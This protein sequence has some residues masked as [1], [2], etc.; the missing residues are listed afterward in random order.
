MARYAYDRLTAQDLSFLLAE[1]D[2]CPMH[3]GA[4][5]V[6][7]SGGLRTESGGI[8]IATCRRT[9]ESVLHWIP[10]YRQ[11]LAWIPVDTWPVWI[12]DR[13]FHLDHHV[14][15]ISL[16]RP[17]TPDQLKELTSRILARP[18]DRSRPLWEIWVIEGLQNGEQF[19]LLNKVH[20][21]MIDGAAGADISQI[22]FSP[23][24]SAE[25][26]DPVAY[27]PRPEPSQIELLTTALRRRALQPLSAVRSL[28]GWLLRS[29]SDAPSQ[30]SKQ[31]VALAELA[32]WTLKPASET[33]ING[34]LSPYRNFDWLT[35]P[36]E[37]VRELRGVL[38]CTINDIVLTTVAGAL[39]R[40]FF[41][42][43]VE[44]GELD[45][46]V[47]AP[48]NVRRA[49]HASRQGNHVSTWI[50]PLPLGEVDPLAQLAAIRE[51]TQEL[52]RSESS[53]GVETLMSIAEWLPAGVLA[54]GAEL[55]QSPVN[56]IVTNVPGPQ[57]PLFFAGARLLGMYP[58]V[59]LMQGGGL[60]LAI[61]SY[62]GKLCWGFNGDSELVPDLGAFVADLG[63]AFEDLRGAA[64]S[65]FMEER[66]A[67]PE[68][69]VPVTTTRKRRGAG[70][71]KAANGAAGGHAH[72]P[73]AA[74]PPPAQEA[75]EAS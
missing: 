63:A 32:G 22:L 14:R 53:R 51:R 34:V 67:E 65:R 56:M 45:F 33:P 69:E 20:H 75:A 71:R 10:R 39:R 38:G 9:V 3:V 52:K 18:L 1:G 44:P 4:V 73:P 31:L 59:P 74:E 28:S 11:K 29:A 7:E 21:C 36:L 35:M 12:D 13:Y 41:R 54:M 43:R 48:V 37:D 70:G 58:L 30:V 16:P 68:V 62:E 2:G 6:L 50:V 17:G 8:D 15:H 27:L 57:F 25:I 64:V 72:P 55:A 42:R 19:A 5:A 66:T 24:A 60:G 46:R 49:E 61:F 26:A 47:A 23:D 40:Y